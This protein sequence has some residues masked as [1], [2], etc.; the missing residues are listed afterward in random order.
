[1]L[2]LTPGSDPYQTELVF[3]FFAKG[4]R[5]KVKPTEYAPGKLTVAGLAV[6]VPPMTLIWAHSIYFRTSAS[7]PPP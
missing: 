4:L 5:T 3:S 6:P 7:G 2:S 1:M